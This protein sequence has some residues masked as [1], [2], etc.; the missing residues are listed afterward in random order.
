MG[1]TQLMKIISDRAPNA[2]KSTKLESYSGKKIAEDVSMRLYKFLIQI[3]MGFDQ[4]NLQ[5]S[6]GESTSHLQGFFYRMINLLEAGIVPYCVFDGKPPD[7]KRYTLNKRDER[8]ED[9]KN[10]LE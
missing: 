7:L 1:I 6:K 5:N 3:R 10:K 4:H 9:S 8:R 2:I